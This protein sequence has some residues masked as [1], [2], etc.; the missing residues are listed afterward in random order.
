MEFDGVY[1]DGR[2]AARHPVRVAVVPGALEIRGPAGEP[3]E[4]W[5]F[6]GLRAVGERFADQPLLFLHRDAGTARLTVADRTIHEALAEVGAPAS[7]QRR[8]RTRF[9]GGRW[10]VVVVV[11]FVLLLVGLLAAVPWLAGPLARSVPTAW[12]ERLGGGLARQ[13]ASGWDTCEG[14]EGNEVLTAL[15]SRL[16]P[17]GDGGRFQVV[18]VD[19]GLVNALALPG[20]HIVLF[21]GLVQQAE[22]ADEL[23]GVLAHE[24]AHVIH[25]H[26]LESLIRDTGISVIFSLAMGN[27]SAIAG[28]GDAML[29]MRY[30]RRTEEEADRTAVVLLQQAQ[31]DSHG[32]IAFF[33]R[34]T[35]EGR[36][37]PGVIQLLSTHPSPTRRAEMLRRY[38]RPGAP[39]LQPEEWEAL[40]SICSPTAS[41]PKDHEDTLPPLVP[42]GHE[43]TIWPSHPKDH[44]TPPNA[45]RFQ[46][47]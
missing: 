28:I 46:R 24:M 33:E 25:R 16:D 17:D 47:P 5:S 26:A 31:I 14:E 20:G 39:A 11:A 12:E 23:A 9:L 32:L 8:V 2:T 4:L 29:Q 38:G 40:Q 19:D 3:V 41:Q 6:D 15:V 21:R 36:D 18:V 1:S 43:D 7:L 42:N 35:E 44:I 27:A 13:L 34:L 30:S 45:P 22:S 37:L 10:L